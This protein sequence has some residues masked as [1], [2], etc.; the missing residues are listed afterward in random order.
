MNHTLSNVIEYCN[1]DVKTIWILYCFELLNYVKCCTTNRLTIEPNK[2]EYTLK[3]KFDN[4][5]L[6]NKQSL[7]KPDGYIPYCI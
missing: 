2:W 6:S 3:I 7:E 5:K 1:T 4:F